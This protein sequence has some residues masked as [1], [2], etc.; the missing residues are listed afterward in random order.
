MEK[1]NADALCCVRAKLIE[2]GWQRLIIGMPQI[3]ALP[4]LGTVRNGLQSS[5]ET[6]K[7]CKIVLKLCDFDHSHGCARHDFWCNIRE[8]SVEVRISRAIIRASPFF[9]VLRAVPIWKFMKWVE[10]VFGSFDFIELLVVR[11]YMEPAAAKKHIRESP[12]CQFMA[13]EHSVFHSFPLLWGFWMDTS[14]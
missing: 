12:R 8:F 2:S 11:Y 14:F 10:G 1:N 6:G 7:F 3:Y 4:F 13:F 5:G 9:Q